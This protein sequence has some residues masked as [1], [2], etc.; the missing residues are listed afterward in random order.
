M[1]SPVSRIPGPS[2]QISV[3]VTNSSLFSDAPRDAPTPRLLARMTPPGTC[4]TKLSCS[5]REVKSRTTL[6]GMQLVYAGPAARSVSSSPSSE[7]AQRSPVTTGVS[8][9]LP[10]PIGPVPSAKHPKIL[11]STSTRGVRTVSQLPSAVASGTA[12]VAS[13]TRNA[14]MR[15]ERSRTRALRPRESAEAECPLQALFMPCACP[16]PLTATSAR[17]TTS[18]CASRE[19]TI[20][21]S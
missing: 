8:Y 21:R 5:T 3:D 14:A 9:P 15:I 6:P 20:S 17:W 11:L 10:P 4:R 19:R 18:Y 13:T 16:T 12:T 1:R 2:A 7:T